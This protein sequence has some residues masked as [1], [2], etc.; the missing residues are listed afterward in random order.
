MGKADRDRRGRA[1]LCGT[2]DGRDG[3]ERIETELAADRARHGAT[4]RLVL[5]T[6]FGRFDTP[7]LR[8]R[9]SR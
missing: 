3:T 7:V 5:P 2:Q 4:K 8:D 1:G 9:P 6:V